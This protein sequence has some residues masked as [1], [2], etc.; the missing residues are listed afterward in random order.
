MGAAVGCGAGGV[1]WGGVA[2]AGV[3]WAEVAAGR[4]PPLPC[5]HASA[6]L[7]IAWRGCA[8]RP[9][10]ARPAAGRALPPPP[11]NISVNLRAAAS[12][13]SEATAR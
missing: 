6:P 4:L 5:S 8:A 7:L 2:Q 10:R 1:E 3:G 9:E 13:G 12:P 11:P